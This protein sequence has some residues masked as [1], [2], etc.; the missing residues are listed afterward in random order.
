[1]YLARVIGRVVATQ[2]Y[3]NLEEVPFQW[4]QPLDEDGEDMGGPLVACAAIGSGPGD[5]VHYVDGREAALASPGDVRP[6]RRRDHRLRRG[7]RAARRTDRRFA[8]VF[9]ADVVGTVVS[10]V[11][12]PILDGKKL[13]L[14]RPLRPDGSPSGKTRVGIDVTGAGEGDRVLVVDEGNAGR[15][16][17]KDPKGPV[18]TLVVGVVDYV[19]DENGALHYDHQDREPVARLDR[20]TK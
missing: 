12:I 8:L 17:L 18:K 13:L 9:L 16:I 10:P 1:M 20:K 3:E 4:I 6:R 11:Q 5:F 15:Q 7:G 14:L 19:E 2:C